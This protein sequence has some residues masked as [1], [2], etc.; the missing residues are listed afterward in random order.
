MEFYR[1]T[2]AE[3]N[4]DAIKWNVQKT[5]EQLDD[6]MFLFAV[7][8]AN[9]YGHGDVQ[10]AREALQAGAKGLAVAFLDEALKLRAAGIDAPILVLGASRPENACLA[11][12]KGISLTVH[13][14][15]WLK[16][17]DIKEGPPLNI[18]IKCDTGMGRIGLK[19]EKE[20]QRVIGQINQSDYLNFEGI[21]T[22]FA[23]A[24]ELDTAYTE[25]QLERFRQ[26]VNSLA[27]KP[28]FVHCSNSAAALR[29]KGTEYNA[30]R[31]GISMYGLTP[32]TEMLPL[33]P[34]E[35]KPAFSLHTK[36][37][38]V[39]LLEPGEK[40]SYGAVYEAKEKQWIGTLPVGYADGWIRKLSGQEVLIDGKRAPIVGRI[41]MDQCMVRLPDEYKTGTKVTL[42]GKQQEEEVTM[43]EIA[44]KR[45]T[46]NYEVPCVIT[47]RVP[48]VYMKNGEIVS[49]ANPLL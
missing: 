9:A 27:A 38:H 39:K 5:L 3:I 28:R 31:L 4:L 29:L 8:K 45:E 32:S 11:A 42:I 19:T 7:V 16:Q 18:H 10:V 12:E 47:S 26:L 24:D 22:H 6:S 37:V 20:L 1:D 23:T 15:E 30:V 17:A 21:F 25:K 43:E 35:L 41:C 48:R 46:I 34:F 13:N 49:I 36:L 40:V 44:Q 14:E 2:W 33:L